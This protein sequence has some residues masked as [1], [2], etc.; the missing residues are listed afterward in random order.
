MI[1]RLLRLAAD[2]SDEPKWYY[3]LLFTVDKTP[4]GDN[5]HTKSHCQPAAGL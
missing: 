5:A 4:A 2:L 3:T 1:L